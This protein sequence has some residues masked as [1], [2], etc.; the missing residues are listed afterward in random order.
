[1]AV[2]LGFGIVFATLI[3]LVLVPCFYTIVEDLRQFAGWRDLTAPDKSRPSDK[4]IS[5]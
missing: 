1:M 5:S 4:L 3:T 2:S